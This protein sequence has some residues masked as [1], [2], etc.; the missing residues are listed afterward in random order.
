MDHGEI[1]AL[2]AVQTLLKVPQGC[3][4][5]QCVMFSVLFPFS[6]LPL[7]RLR[8]LSAAGTLC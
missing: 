2:V 5:I 1:E 3:A 4:T 8:S 6:V 7:Q